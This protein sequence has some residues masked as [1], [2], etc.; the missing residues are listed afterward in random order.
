MPRG[1]FMLPAPRIGQNLV[2]IDRKKL[3]SLFRS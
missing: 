1:G 2:K 3:R